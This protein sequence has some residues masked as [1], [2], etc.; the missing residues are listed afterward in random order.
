MR[1]SSKAIVG[2]AGISVLA[3]SYRIGL[4]AETGF[5]APEFDLAGNSSSGPSP[6]SGAEGS[7]SAHDS[8]ASASPSES[9]TSGSAESGTPS[10][11]PK[12]G[13]TSTS[14]PKPTSTAAP[15]DPGGAPAD[16][17]AAPA[18]PGGA[19]A[20]QT[21]AAIRYKYGT[22]QISVTKSNG[23]ITAVDLVKG[24]A[25]DGRSQAFPAL[26][27]AALQAALPQLVAKLAQDEHAAW[28]VD[29]GG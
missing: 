24:T 9:A 21:G 17:G 8:G 23:S 10:T 13:Q 20:V 19:I 11:K 14:K 6:D 18:D 25:T 22:V 26:L 15:A 29:N 7:A 27:K 4:D 3:A 16:P 1:Y 5:S 2:L 28:A 12:P